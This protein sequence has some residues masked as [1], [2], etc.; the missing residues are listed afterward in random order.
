MFAA[1]VLTKMVIFGKLA[2]Q[3]DENIDKY[4]FFSR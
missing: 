1:T 4:I 3:I 2:K